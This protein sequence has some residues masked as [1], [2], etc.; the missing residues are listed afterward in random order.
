M[1]D[2]RSSSPRFSSP[3]LSPMV[4]PPMLLLLHPIPPR[5]PQDKETE[6]GTRHSALRRRQ[7]EFKRTVKIGRGRSLHLHRAQIVGHHF[8][9]CLPP[10]PCLPAHLFAETDKP[11]EACPSLSRGNGLRVLQSA[12][13]HA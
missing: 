12:S 8:N 7:H 9:L 2:S 4:L 5:I 13:L 1:L 3:R 11:K 6:S 10:H